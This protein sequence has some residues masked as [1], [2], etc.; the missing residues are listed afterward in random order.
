MPL[1][2]YFPYWKR[3]ELGPLHKVSYKESNDPDTKEKRYSL[4][5]VDNNGDE[6]T[7]I[8]KFNKEDF[9]ERARKFLREVS[10]ERGYRVKVIDLPRGED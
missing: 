6:H 2:D 8:S 7:E 9:C 10:D 5:V 4:F 3:N 1:E